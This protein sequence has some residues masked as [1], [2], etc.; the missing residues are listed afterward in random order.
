MTEPQAT[1][2][3]IREKLSSLGAG[4]D[5][6]TVPDLLKLYEPLQAAQNTK[7]TRAV[8][9]VTTNYGPHERHR[10]DIYQPVVFPSGP[11]LPVVAY[12]HGG[13]YVGGDTQVTPNI[14]ANVGNYFASRG[15]VVC[16][17]TYRLAFQGAHFPDGAI[18]VADAL[19][20][21]RDNISPYGGDPNRVVALGQ[22]AGGSHLASALFLGL[23]DG[24]DGS[25]PLLRGAV[26]LSAAFGSN[27]D[28]EMYPILKEYFQTD[29]K[30]ELA[31]R[32]G[33]GALFR[34]EFFG[35]HDKAPRKELPC[36]LLVLLAEWEAEEIVAG[37]LEWFGDYRRRFRRLPAVEVMKGHNHVSY[38]FGLGLEAEEY[39]RTGRRLVEFVREATS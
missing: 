35:S 4:W 15:H 1:I 25:A 9:T 22:S 3:T 32:W 18:D 34:Q 13:G 6:N 17:I 20:W 14:Y 12:I 31:T 38:C 23:L 5:A 10:I 30:G 16:N 27:P 19:R 29:D 24:K 7:G 39:E 28:G 2:A 36:E 26:L 8:V 33:P 21:V 11:T 37:A